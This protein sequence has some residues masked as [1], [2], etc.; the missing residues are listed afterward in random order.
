MSRIA[1]AKCPECGARLD[2]EVGRPTV[3][4]EFCGTRC[5]VYDRP[6]WFPGGGLDDGDLEDLPVIRLR[7]PLRWVW[8]SV[9]AVF[10]AAIVA[11]A[12]FSLRGVGGPPE[13]EADE[14]LRWVG[15]APGELMTWDGELQAM[16]ADVNGDGYGDPLGWVRFPAARTG[17]DYH[18]AAFGALDGARLWISERLALAHRLSSSRVAIVQGVVV[19]VDSGGLL[20]GLSLASGDVAFSAVMGQRA[21]R[22]CDGGPG[23][24]RV[25]LEDGTA[26]TVALASGQV[27]GEGPVDPGR[28]CDGVWSDRGRRTPLQSHRFAL[29]GA[30]VG[31]LPR[32]DGLDAEEMVYD[33]TTGL[34]AVLG[35]VRLEITE[36]KHVAAFDP[37]TPGPRR[38]LHRLARWILPVFSGTDDYTPRIEIAGRTTAA[39]GVLFVTYRLAN[40]WRMTAVS[41]SSGQ[42]FFDRSLPIGDSPGGVTASR[43]QVFLSADTALHVFDIQGG[44]LRMS[45]G[46]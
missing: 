40:Q 37:R 46:G 26:L 22:V 21:E 16:V 39:H 3:R 6:T 42:R 27:V 34:A 4:C 36:Q 5:R 45:I 1:S 43:H 13:E 32:L 41:L 9:A 29:T 18:L 17:Y 33:T 24:V 25:E 28:T 44:A 2:I 8:A 7:S 11:L 20:R 38:G 12:L 10:L 15:A 30:R 35:D 19:H 14:T 31:D 23:L